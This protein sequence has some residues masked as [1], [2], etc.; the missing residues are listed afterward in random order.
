M[1]VKKLASLSFALALVYF[2]SLPARAELLKNFKTDGSIE[3]RSFSIDNEIDRNGTADDYRSETR[4]RVLVGGSFDVWDDV[5]GRVAVRKNDRVFGN[6]GQRAAD[7]FNTSVTANFF[8]D[9][10]YV[11]VDKVF[12]R[13]DLT[14]GRQYYGDPNDPVI[15]FG[16]N[17]DDVLSV[18]ALDAFRVD[19]DLAGWAKFQG[20]YAKVADNGG[21]AAFGNFANAPSRGTDTDNAIFGGEVSTD[22]VVPKGNLGVYYYTDQVKTTKVTPATGN[23]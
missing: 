7:G 14:M 20:I 9:N 1:S 11:K 2:V 12:G 5:H 17:N 4:T 18:G 6:G 22:K 21:T 19:A 3:T 13:L 23:N 10:A 8:V 16:P 15:Y